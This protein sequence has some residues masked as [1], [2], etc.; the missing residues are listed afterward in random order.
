MNLNEKSVIMNLRVSCDSGCTGENDIIV[1]SPS[2]TWEY[3]WAHLTHC[4]LAALYLIK[5]WRCNF[6]ILCPVLKHIWTANI[7]ELQSHDQTWIMNDDIIKWVWWTL[8][9]WLILFNNIQTVCSEKKVKGQKNDQWAEQKSSSETGRKQVVTSGLTFNIQRS[10]PEHCLKSYCWIWIL[11]TERLQLLQ[12]LQLTVRSVVLFLVK[13]F[14]DDWSVTLWW[15]D[16]GHEEDS[17]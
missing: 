17:D 5:L 8:I 14:C 3:R 2:D 4:S 9:S 12:M 11:L 10:A 7:T 13:E 16:G 6:L 1:N 15:S